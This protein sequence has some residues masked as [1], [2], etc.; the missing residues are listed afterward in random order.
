M[1]L[2]CLLLV[3]AS[4]A[5]GASTSDTIM[6]W[7]DSE[8]G[9][10]DVASREQVKELLKECNEA[11]ITSVAVDVKNYA[12][13]AFYK[14]AIVPR[15]KEWDTKLYPENYDLLKTFVEEAEPLGIK[16]FAAINVFSEGLKK[17]RIGPVYSH[18]EWEA[19]IYDRVPYALIRGGEKLDITNI[20]E[21]AGADALSYFDRNHVTRIYKKDA[22][23]NAID[24]NTQNR[25]SVWVSDDSKAPHFLELRLEQQIPIASIR[26]FFVK[27][28]IPRVFTIQLK[29]NDTIIESLRI[30]DNVRISPQ[31]PLIKK[32]VVDTIKIEFTDCGFD[33]IARVMEATITTSENGS[34]MNLAETASIRADSFMDRGRGLFAVVQNDK[35]TTVVAEQV[36]AEGGLIIPQNGALVVADGDARNHLESHLKPGDKITFNSE[37]RLIRE[38]EYPK[39]I[40]VYVN[41][42]NTPVQDRILRIIREIM[43]TYPVEGIILDRVRY[44]NFQIDF[45]AESRHA[46]ETWLGQKVERFPADIYELPDPFIGGELK[47][48]EFFKQW[49]EWRA[50]TIRDFIKRIRSTVDES[51]KE[52][53]LGDYVGGWYPEYWQVGVNWASPHYDPSLEFGWA[54][55]TYKDTGYAHL[56]DFLSPGL[57]YSYITT[58]EAEQN[59]LADY[60]SIEGGIDL[61]KRVVADSTRVIT[62]LYYPNLYDKERFRTAVRMSLSR[63]DGVMIFS[64]HYFVTHNRWDVLNFSIQD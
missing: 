55:E 18:P 5:F 43:D 25:Y 27:G 53:L 24:G 33:T 30:N 50:V 36:L 35:V 10:F 54:T 12:G 19:I 20:N 56:L 39:G 3:V 21:R 31:Y 13:L 46:F 51:D 58:A 8:H 62:G 11:G 34:P 45:S 26:L 32:P 23:Q 42:I 49:I 47:K 29:K 60:Y 4:L 40:L 16:V 63:T 2:T 44:D 28:F 59:G 57:Y 17:H 38:S 7:I 37:T 6:L 48:G 41:P 14:S 61:V 9:V 64:H 22:P 1:A 15:V 52:I